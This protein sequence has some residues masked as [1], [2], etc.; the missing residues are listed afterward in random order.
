M[1]F[2]GRTSVIGA[3]KKKKKKGRTLSIPMSPVGNKNLI[4]N[5]CFG[6]IS[7]KRKNVVV[8]SG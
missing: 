6:E 8:V 5:I 3:K 2:G 1:N 4:K 7:Q